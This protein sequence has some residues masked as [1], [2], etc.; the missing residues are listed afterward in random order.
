MSLNQIQPPKA[1]YINPGRLWHLTKAEDVA[2]FCRHGWDSEYESNQLY[3]RGLAFSV[4]PEAWT[5]IAKLGGTVPVEVRLPAGT[6]I[7]D[8]YGTFGSIQLENIPAIKAWAIAKGHAKLSKIYRA[9]ST[10]EE[11]EDRYFIHNTKEEA[12]FEADKDEQDKPRV[13]EAEGLSCLSGE[14]LWHGRAQD[15]LRQYVAENYP[16]VSAVWYND[17]LDPNN[18]SAPQGYVL[19]GWEKRVRLV[20]PKTPRRSNGFNL[21]QL[22]AAKQPKLILYRGE[23]TCGQQGNYYT[24]DREWARQF[25]QSG[26]NHEIRVIQLDPNLIYRADVLPRAFGAED[27][28]FDQAIAEAKRQG[29]KAIWVD[30]GK[31]QPNSVFVFGTL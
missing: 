4:H 26:Q 8:I 1:H 30:E 14:L 28:A 11:G 2:E 6:K 18:Y 5:H 9:Y 24:A 7:L 20:P 15:L 27:P 21:K 17:D 3:G 10:G 22:H 31:G 29:K 13:E 12:D 25:T 19:P 16:G 23:M